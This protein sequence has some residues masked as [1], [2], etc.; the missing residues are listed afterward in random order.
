MTNPD[1]S[2]TTVQIEAV[3]ALIRERLDYWI[4]GGKGLRSEMLPDLA[5]E[6]VAKVE[7]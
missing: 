4:P 5:R 6:I 7:E 1:L 2:E 3:T